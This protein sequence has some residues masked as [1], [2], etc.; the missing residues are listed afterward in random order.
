MSLFLTSITASRW[1][2][3]SGACNGLTAATHIKLSVT[4]ATANSSPIRCVVKSMPSLSD[5]IWRITEAYHNC[6]RVEC[7]VPVPTLIPILILLTSG[8]YI[9]ILYQEKYWAAPAG[10]TILSSTRSP[11][12]LAFAYSYST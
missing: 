5:K 6:L 9:D 12:H 2:G 7:S 4:L 10:E 3:S 8:D 11:L 1:A